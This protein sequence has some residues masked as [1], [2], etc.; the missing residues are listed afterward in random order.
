M[1][2]MKTNLP[3]TLARNRVYQVS[4]AKK[5]PGTKRLAK[6][7]GVAG[8]DVGAAVV[9]ALGSQETVPDKRRWWWPL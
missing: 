8:V 3:T 7:S 9:A 5:K 1:N 6:D 2:S 4:P